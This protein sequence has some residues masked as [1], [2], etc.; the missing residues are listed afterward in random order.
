MSPS[1]KNNFGPGN[2]PTDP[3]QQSFRSRE[4]DIRNDM[5]NSMRNKRRLEDDRRINRKKNDPNAMT[6][7]TRNSFGSVNTRI[8]PNQQNFGSRNVNLR[9]F[10]GQQRNVNANSINTSEGRR[11]S[12]VYS[13]FSPQGSVR[14][15][16]R[17]GRR[18]EN[19]RNV[20]S[21][22]VS[23]G[24]GNEIQRDFGTRI[25]NQGTSSRQPSNVYSN[26]SPQSSVRNSFR[27]GRRLA[28]DRNVNSGEVGQG[29]GNEIQRDFGT[30]IRNQGTSSNFNPRQ[31]QNVND[32]AVNTNIARRPSSSY[33]NFSPQRS[34][35]SSFRTAKRL[36]EDRNVNDAE[37]S[38]VE[39]D[40]NFNEGR[41][42][43]R[44]NPSGSR[45]SN[46][47]QNDR[48][49]QAGAR[50]RNQAG[51][52]QRN[53]FRPNSIFDQTQR[54]PSNDYSVANSN[55]GKIIVEFY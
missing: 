9:N 53:P 38:Q 39:N 13:N 14:N 37:R 49:N 42:N 50:G 33:S 26:F 11:P 44:R 27:D 35:S 1:T 8:R 28:D 12:T 47:F 17:D 24:S 48:R 16:F 10:Q 18:L 41:T 54:R 34:Q 2:T 5:S 4:V 45:N 7:S 55:Q 46:S 51:A 15:S 30:R 20:N 6:A 3:N 19:D 40:N 29:S 21:G 31:Q 52:G 23:P 36:N 25:R 32:I 22:E 43:G